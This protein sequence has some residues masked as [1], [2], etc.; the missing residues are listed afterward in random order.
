MGA[1][2]QFDPGF[3]EIMQHLIDLDT[4]YE[5]REKREHTDDAQEEGLKREEQKWN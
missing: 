2:T 4:N 5:M 3:A 1:G